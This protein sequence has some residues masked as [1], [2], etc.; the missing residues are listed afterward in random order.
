MNGSPGS[1]VGIKLPFNEM[2]FFRAS[3]FSFFAAELDL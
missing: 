2:D 3:L 1:W